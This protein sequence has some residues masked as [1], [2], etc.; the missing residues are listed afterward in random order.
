L[1]D[2][3]YIH[4]WQKWQSYRGDRGQPPWIKLHRCLLRERKWIYLSDQQRCHLLSIW[5]LAADE[6]GCIP[7]D[8]KFIKRACCLESE[9]DLKF[10]V[11]NG[12]LDATA[13][14]PRRQLDFP[15]AETETETEKKRVE[16]N[17]IHASLASVVDAKHVEAVLRHRK[18]IKQP[19]TELA[20]QRLAK[21]LA[22][23]SD[24]NEA[25]DEMV[26]RGWR[27]FDPDWMRNKRTNGSGATGDPPRGKGAGFAE[28]AFNIIKEARDK[29]A[30]R[31]K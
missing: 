15:E 28:T 4:N 10:F 1:T 23:W 18:K 17:N 14:P 16:K 12:F 29:D 3:L 2:F 13:T 26:L 19:L 27:G 25:V 5:L 9:P 7:N 31:K 21:Q 20:A 24:P 11:D 30:A 22:K 6:E 8:A